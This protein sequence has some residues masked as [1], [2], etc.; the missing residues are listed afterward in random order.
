LGETTQTND[1]IEQ[2]VKRRE[3]QNTRS[4]SS[5]KRQSTIQ[6]FETTQLNEP[7]EQMDDNV[8]NEVDESSLTKK[9]FSHNITFTLF[10][11]IINEN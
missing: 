4:D 2:F 1:F 5:S 8:D 6:T 3:K 9:Y 10:E 7:N 11:I